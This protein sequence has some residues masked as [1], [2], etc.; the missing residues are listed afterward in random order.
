MGTWLAGEGSKPAY[1]RKIDQCGL[2][3]AD[4]GFVAVIAP[5]DPHKRAK[6]LPNAN[7]VL[8]LGY[9]AA[10]VGWNRVIL[11]MN[12]EY[13]PPEDLIFDLR[14]QRFPVTFKVGPDTRK[15]VEIDGMAG[16]TLLHFDAGPYSGGVNRSEETPDS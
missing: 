6:R 15:D 16:G 12:L 7:V 5:K 3:L 10:R 14:H 1:F 8:E 4:V 13:G 11:V 2:F 9:A